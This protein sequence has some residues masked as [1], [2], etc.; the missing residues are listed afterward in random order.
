M[1]LNQQAKT[2]LQKL[3]S[4][5]SK[6]IENIID[7]FAEALRSN[8]YHEVLNIRGD[9]FSDE[10]LDAPTA[11]TIINVMQHLSRYIGDEEKKTEFLKDI[12]TLGFS[13]SELERIK[14]IVNRLQETGF[15]A[16]YA[17]INRRAELENYGP[18]K[19]LTLN[20]IS[21]YRLFTKIDGTKEFIPIVTWDMEIGRR[22]DDGNKESQ[23][24]TF[25]LSLD[26]LDVTI[27]YLQRF[28]KGAIE[29]I[30]DLKN[31]QSTIGVSNV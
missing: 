7:T 27:E 23:R 30:E 17:D 29:E 3:I 19:L 11:N 10:Q 5:P 18:P 20:I 12:E 6:T 24:I 13:P 28:R 15:T 2:D 16:F 1:S 21:D 31:R 8:K 9:N 22:T 4:V 14:Y 25:Q 26:Q